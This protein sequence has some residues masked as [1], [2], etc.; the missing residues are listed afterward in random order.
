MGPS[1][2]KKL[3]KAKIESLEELF[4]MDVDSI[5]SIEGIGKKTAE[6]IIK[7]LAKIIEDGK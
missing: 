6:L 4:E 1:V 7:K 5:V 2:V 3:E